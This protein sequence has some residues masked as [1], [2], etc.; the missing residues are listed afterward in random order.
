MPALSA[1]A[2]AVSV[3]RELIIDP[4]H[5]TSY[6]TSCLRAVHVRLCFTAIPNND[7][8]TVDVFSSKSGRKGLDTLIRGSGAVRNVAANGLRL[9]AAV[10]ETPDSTVAPS[11][12]GRLLRRRAH[13]NRSSEAPPSRRAMNKTYA[14][15]AVQW[16]KNTPGTPVFTL[17][18]DRC[19]WKRYLRHVELYLETD[20]LDVDLSHGARC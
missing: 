2:V 18:G 13:S 15:K 10:V 14:A 5:S 9:K 19:Q 17:D 8:H 16:R 4:R 12:A 20:Q 6:S 3:V 1:A 11:S 7:F